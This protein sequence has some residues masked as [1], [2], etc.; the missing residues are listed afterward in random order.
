MGGVSTRAG[1][2][3]GGRYGTPRPHRRGGGRL[4]ALPMA[5]A[6]PGM[7][8]RRRRRARPERLWCAGTGAHPRA[9]RCLCPRP[10]AGFRGEVRG[11]G[12][13]RRGADFRRRR[14]RVRGAGRARV[15]HP[16]APP[17]GA[18]GDAVAAGGRGRGAAGTPAHCEARAEGRCSLP[19]CLA[20]PLAP[21]G[22]GGG[23]RCRCGRAVPKAGHGSKAGCKIVF[24]RLVGGVP[25]GNAGGDASGAG[26]QVPQR[27][28]GRVPGGRP[29]A[30]V[31]LLGGQRAPPGGW[32]VALGT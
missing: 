9:R 27:R 22:W 28:H 5:R 17:E 10:A 16:A 6:L 2:S 12:A 29:H 19:L 25:H 21:D 11:G 24:V 32:L 3:G 1:R 26:G 15:L 8:R 4:S 31:L 20:L 14:G 30:P 13:P 23:G 7:R 18:G